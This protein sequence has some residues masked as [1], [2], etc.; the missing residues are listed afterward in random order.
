MPPVG[1]DTEVLSVLSAAFFSLCGSIARAAQW[2]DPKTGKFMWWKIAVEI[3]TALFLGEVALGIEGYF[4][5]D[6]RATYALAGLLG[7]LGP[8]V[9]ATFFAQR[10]EGLKSFGK[11]NDKPS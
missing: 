2:R 6:S 8:A 9:V 5:I 3:A 4:N 7:Y 1:N 11:G 10:I